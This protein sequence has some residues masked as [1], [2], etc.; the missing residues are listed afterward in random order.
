MLVTKPAF[1]LFTTVF[2]NISKREII[3]LTTSNLSSANAFNLDKSGILLCGN[4]LNKHFLQ[5][6]TFYIYLYLTWQISLPRTNIF[7]KNMYF[8]FPWL[9]LNCFELVFLY[10]QRGTLAWIN[11]FFKNIYSLLFHGCFQVLYNYSELVFNL[12]ET[13]LP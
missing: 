13:T 11:S 2:C 8:S 12:T 9:F 4:K 10:W 3:I 5:K 1:S 7:Y 6:H